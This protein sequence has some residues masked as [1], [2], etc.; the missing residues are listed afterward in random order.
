MLVPFKIYAD[1]EFNLESVESYEGSLFNTLFTFTFSELCNLENE[2]S[3]ISWIKSFDI[4]FAGTNFD[5]I[6]QNPQNLRKLL[7]VKIC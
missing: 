6:V 4:I 7:P 3:R 5:R 1:S 2:I